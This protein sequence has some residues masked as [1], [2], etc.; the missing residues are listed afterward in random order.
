MMDQ[1][2]YLIILQNWALLNY[3]RFQRVMR[4]WLGNGS[5]IRDKPGVLAVMQFPVNE[6]LKP[7]Q[8]YGTR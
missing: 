5:D 7:D 3:K 2:I 6:P 1:H 4:R 8:G